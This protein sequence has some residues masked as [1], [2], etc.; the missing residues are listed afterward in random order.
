MPHQGLHSYVLMH[1]NIVAVWCSYCAWTRGTAAW[2]LF[3]SPSSFSTFSFYAFVT[4][5]VL[6]ARWCFQVMAQAVTLRATALF[7][8]MHS[9]IVNGHQLLCDAHTVLEPHRGTAA[10]FLFYSPSSFSTFSFYV[11]VNLTVLFSFLG[12]SLVY[13]NNLKRAADLILWFPDRT[14][15]C[16]HPWLDAYINTSV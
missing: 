16:P 12:A 3:Y 1:S 6:V 15:V 5:T 10:L 7:V 2:F 13:V 14:S 8:L 4:L 11:F 9:G